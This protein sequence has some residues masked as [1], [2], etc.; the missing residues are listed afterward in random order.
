M[1]SFPYFVGQF[2]KP[3]SPKKSGKGLTEYVLRTGKALL[4]DDTLFNT[5]VQRAEVELT[6]EPSPIWLGV[7][8]QIGNKII[9]VVA[10][11]DYE[12]PETYGVRQKEILEYVSSQIAH[13]I[14]RK[15]TETVLATQKSFFQ[16]L[17]DESPSGIAIL[18]TEDTIIDVN[19]AFKEMFQYSR[20]KACGEK[21]NACIVPAEYMAEAEGFSK[22]TRDGAMSWK[23]T[24]RRRKDGT[25]IHVRV[26][27]YPIVIEGKHS[28][29][30]A[31][32]EDISEQKKFQQQFIQSQ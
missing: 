23:E 32:Y 7:P 8:L 21:I 9:G 18:D 17:F 22:I 13:T 15:Q 11:Q 3:I 29:V 4:C 2:D 26:T 31:I 28:G 6:G 20:D 14:E 25:L 10:V 27:G 12:N 24:Q 30:Y 5:L 19:R 16:Q 1:I